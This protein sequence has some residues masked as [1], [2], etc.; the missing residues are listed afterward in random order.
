M[1]NIIVGFNNYKKNYG[2]GQTYP[3]TAQ[4]ISFVLHE[5]NDCAS[6]PSVKMQVG[7]FGVTCWVDGNMN[8]VQVYSNGQL[9]IDDFMFTAKAA[10]NG[11]GGGNDATE[12]ENED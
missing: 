3:N 11:E 5:T 8:D 6:V 10:A 12:V 1:N 7:I 9:G 4:N 2:N